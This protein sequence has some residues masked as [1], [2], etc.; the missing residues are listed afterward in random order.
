MLVSSLSSPP[1]SSSSSSSLTS[2]PRVLALSIVWW[3]AFVAG[4]I[5]GHV[6][7]ALGV[8]AVVIVAVALRDRAL[9]SRLFVGPRRDV[10]VDV[11]VGVVVGVASIVVTHGAYPLLARATPSLAPE[12][13]RLY[14]LAGVTPSTLVATELVV[15]AEEVLWRGAVVAALRGRGVLPAVAQASSAALYAAAQ[16]GGGSSWLVAAALG[17]GAVWGALAVLRGGR[18]VA[19]LIAHALWTLVILGAWPLVP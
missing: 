16:S 14:V 1:S 6:Y 19:P 8:V 9:R 2:L 4:R 18:I 3:C 10:V 17:L 13:A 12:I 11:V 15:L 7:A 5:G